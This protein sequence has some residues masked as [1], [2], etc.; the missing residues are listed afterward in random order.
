M[1]TVSVKNSSIPGLIKIQ[2]RALWLILIICIAISTTSARKPPLF[3]LDRLDGGVYNLKTDLGKSVILLE[4]WGT[5]CRAKLSNLRAIDDLYSQY[6]NRGLKVY[7]IN[8][9]DAS[10]RSRI[11]PAVKKYG[12]S[13]PILLDPAKE[14]LRTFSPTKKIPFTVIIGLNGEIIHESGGNQSNTHRVIKTLVKEQLE[15]S[16]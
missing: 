2:I 14:I 8:V 15:N 11:K 4:F 1:S 16:N 3:R 13:F 6:K 7:A 10:S 12:Y 9:D 5:C